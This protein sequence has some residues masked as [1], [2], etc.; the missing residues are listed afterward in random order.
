MRRSLPG[1]ALGAVLVS[2]LAACSDQEPTSLPGP[3]DAAPG[4]EVDADAFVEA[5]EQGFDDGSTAT[6]RFDI[7][8]RTRIGGGGVVRYDEDGM[9]LDLVID[10]WQVRGAEVSLRVLD[11]ATYLRLPESR[12]LWVDITA[13]ESLQPDEVLAEADL[14]NHVEEIRADI[15][16]VRFSGDDTVGGEPAR[17]YQVV[18]DAGATRGEG[19]PPPAV[20]EYWF[21][22]DGRVVRRRTDVDGSGSA[23]FTWSAWDEPA[24][25]APPA[26]DRVV[27][28]RELEQL[29][30]RGD[31][32]AN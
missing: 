15:S 31:R 27:T 30:R 18:T 5:L 12:G 23:T 20:T 14:R 21:D 7:R 26:A 16:E 24:S 6:V 32:A 28:L 19:G 3:A 1:L 10:D 2:G 25:I 9:D 13:E 29:R 4:E 11:G 17:R 8:G 22:A